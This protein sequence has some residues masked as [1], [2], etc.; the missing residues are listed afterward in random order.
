MQFVNNV[1]NPM[2]KRLFCCGS[3]GGSFLL[4][5]ASSWLSLFPVLLRLLRRFFVLV[6][7]VFEL[8]HV[9]LKKESGLGRGETIGPIPRSPPSSSSMSRSSKPFPPDGNPKLEKSI[10]PN[11]KKIHVDVLLTNLVCQSTKNGFFS[12]QQNFSHKNMHG[13]FRGR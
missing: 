2:I 1:A 8:T 10:P 6:L 12:T 11:A 5:V 7:D 9:I 4:L 3:S 13:N